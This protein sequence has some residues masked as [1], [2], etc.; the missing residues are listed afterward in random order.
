MDVVK[1]RGRGK[2]MAPLVGG[3]D[4]RSIA[5][6]RLVRKSLSAS[7]IGAMRTPIVVLGVLLLGAGLVWMAQGLNLPFAPR[8]FMTSDRSWIVIG[9]VA[10]VAGVVLIGR[11]RRSA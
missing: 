4:G 10:A 1:G 7:T 11:A 6:A 8:S 5:R 2:A 9:A 3:Y